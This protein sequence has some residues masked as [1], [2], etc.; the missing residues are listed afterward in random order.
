VR[1]LASGPGPWFQYDVRLAVAETGGR[2]GAVIDTIAFSFN[3]GDVEYTPRTCGA[4]V[5][6]DQT[7]EWDS[8]SD[9]R[10]SGFTVLG[11]RPASCSVT[12][13]FVSDDGSRGQ[14]RKV[15]SLAD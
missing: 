11:V 4:A 6:I 2:T 13:S 8:L 10:C 15:V 5:H 12:V 7:S 1:P 9:A 14:L 3:T